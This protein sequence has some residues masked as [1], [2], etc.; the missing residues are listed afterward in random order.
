MMTPGTYKVF[1]DDEGIEQ[2]LGDVSF[3]HYRIEPYTPEQ[4]AAIKSDPL[5]R[6]YVRFEVNCKLCG[7]VFK[8][9]AGV[10]KSKASE[11]QGY[12]WNF[13]IQESEFVCS[14]GKTRTN[15]DYIKTGLHGYLQRNL[16]PLTQTNVSAVRMYEKRALE[17]SCE[18]FLKLIE[19]D[20]EEEVVQKFLESHE[21]FFNLFM[22]KQINIKPPILTKY[23]ADFAV[24]NGRN[25]LLL[26]EIERP[27]LTCPQLS[28][29]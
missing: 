3:L 2:Y 19:D 17:Q 24:L 28:F 8:A 22:P 13:E 26:I 1:L 6:K 5:A 10:E 27:N 7:D 11:D 20:T 25:E 29:T 18:E 16:A 4:I 9:Y 23:K 15:L 21:I 12:R 14:C